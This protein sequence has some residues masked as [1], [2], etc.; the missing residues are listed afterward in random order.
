MRRAI[1]GHLMAPVPN[2]VHAQFVFAA[3]AGHVD[4]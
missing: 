1:S 3:V 4:E 2:A